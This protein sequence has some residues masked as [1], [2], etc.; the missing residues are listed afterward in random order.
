MLVQVSWVVDCTGKLGGMNE[1]SASVALSAACRGGHV[2]QAVCGRVYDVANVLLVSS[3]SDDDTR[4]RYAARSAATGC[5]VLVDV[6]LSADGHS[7]ALR[8]NCE[9]I[10]IGQMLL[11]DL[12]TALARI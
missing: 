12:R 6:K 8:V 9:M 4:L 2:V 1:S 11:N 7:A 3:A 5:E 10:V